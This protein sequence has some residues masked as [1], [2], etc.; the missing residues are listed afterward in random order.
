MVKRRVPTVQKIN[1]DNEMG[2]FLRGHIRSMG[3]TDYDMKRPVIGVCNPWSELNPGHWHFRD[4]VTPLSGA[5]GQPG[6]SH[7]SSRPS[8]FVR[9]F[10]ISQP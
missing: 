4:W 2:G 3:Y 6:G 8:R 5:S 9:Y 10:M 1:L 7:W